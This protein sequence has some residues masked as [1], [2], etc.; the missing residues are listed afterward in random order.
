MAD[1]DADE[2]RVMVEKLDRSLPNPS[3]AVYFEQYGGGPSEMK[4]IATRDGYLRL[5]VELLKAAIAAE[6]PGKPNAVDLDISELVHPQSAVDF[7]WFERRPDISTFPKEM[8]VGWSGRA[9][10]AAIVGFLV[11]WSFAGCYG[12]VAFLTRK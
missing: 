4:F 6:I 1:I 11:L 2:L 5:G 12:L 3:K 8:E 10:A 9:I 7:D